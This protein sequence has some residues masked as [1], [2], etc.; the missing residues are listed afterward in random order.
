MFSERDIGD[1]MRWLV[2]KAVVEFD[3][4]RQEQAAVQIAD[5][6]G[7]ARVSGCRAA[8]GCANPSKKRDLRKTE[9]NLSA[10][11]FFDAAVCG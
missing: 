2:W 4:V 11:R 6:A 5:F 9:Q 10:P 1:L 3:A 7:K 8:S